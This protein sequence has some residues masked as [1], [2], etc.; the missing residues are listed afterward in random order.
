MKK[1]KE[2]PAGYAVEGKQNKG[3]IREEKRTVDSAK[4]ELYD[5]IKRRRCEAK[6]EGGGS[7]G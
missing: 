4:F 6:G 7:V 3:N 5:E 1:L 2:N